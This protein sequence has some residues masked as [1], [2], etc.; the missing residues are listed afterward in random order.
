MS[1]IEWGGGWRDADRV[2]CCTNPSSRGRIYT[3]RRGEGGCVWVK[4][5]TFGCDV[6][7]AD[8]GRAVSPPSSSL[9]KAQRTRSTDSQ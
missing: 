9:Q 1:R 4:G 3:Q 5:K 8:R 6:S 7:R 2:P